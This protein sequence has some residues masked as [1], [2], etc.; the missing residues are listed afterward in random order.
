M[1]NQEKVEITSLNIDKVEEIVFLN[2]T[3]KV[4]FKKIKK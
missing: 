4:F 3:L 2:E 1:E